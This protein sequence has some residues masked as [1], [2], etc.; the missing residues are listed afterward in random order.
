MR[1]I[2]LGFLSV[3]AAIADVGAQAH[4]YDHI[5]LAAADQAKAVAWY[6]AHFGAVPGA[7]PDRVVIGRTI[8]AFIKRE[9][10]P[11]SAGSA[12][13]HIGL[14]FPD[15][16]AKVRELEMDG[17][18]VLTPPRD[19]PNLFRL[20]FVE[21]PF[22]IKIELVQDAETPGFHHIH[23]RV[24]DPEATLT[25][26]HAALGGERVKLKGQ[27]DAVKFMNPNV[28]LLAQKAADAPPTAGRAIDHLGWTTADTD[29]TV[30]ELRTKPGVTITTEPRMGGHLRVALFDD[31]SG[32][33]VEVVQNRK[34][35]EIQP[36][37]GGL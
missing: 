27:L 19:V 30:A 8:F 5:H 22:G 6:I 25:W 28:W 13:D 2:V 24:P 23:L 29:A 1:R 10:S 3:L 14:S 9:S 36:K 4:R 34:E 15:L 7:T 20:A 21:D 11:P 26:Y 35:E 16:D 32:I 17:A 31:P 12:V 18:K 33:R 37:R